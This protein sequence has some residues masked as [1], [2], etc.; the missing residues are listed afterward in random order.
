[1]DNIY[2]NK[3]V[4]VWPFEFYRKI[5]YN[6]FSLMI[7]YFERM[8][9]SDKSKRKDKNDSPWWTARDRKEHDGS[10]V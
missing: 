4:F 8:D 6:I 10:R 2:N 7:G 3:I 1:M 9:T 5:K